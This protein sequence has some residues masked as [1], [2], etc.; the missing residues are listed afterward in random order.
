MSRP[1]TRSCC[2]QGWRIG[3]SNSSSDFLVVGC[4]PPGQQPDLL[5][6]DLG[7]R[8]KADAN[9]AKVAMPFSDPVGGS[10][11]PLLR[12]WKGR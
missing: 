2:L 7:D 11:G 1:G 10:G 3:G 8:Q 6:G 4:Y 5:R 12:H 9:I